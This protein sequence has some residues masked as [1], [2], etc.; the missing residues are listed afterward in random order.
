MAI[1]IVVPR[2]GWSMDEGTFV[3]WLI[4]DGALVS[5]GDM[6]YEL[7]GEKT[8]EEIESFDEGI[9]YIPADAPRPGDT[10]AVGTRLAYLLAE[11][12]TPPVV[13]QEEYGSSNV[14]RPSQENEEVPRQDVR[15]GNSPHG[16]RGGEQPSSARVSASPRALR[17]ARELGVDCSNIQGSGRNG[18]VRQRDVIAVAGRSSAPNRC[19]DEGASLAAR[20]PSSK[21]RRTIAHRMLAGAQQTAPVTLTTRV[22]ASGLVSVRQGFKAEG[23]PYVPSYNDF[24]VKLV[25]VS[26]TECPEMNASWGNNAVEFN[27]EIN[28][29]IAVDT[30]HGLVAPVLRSVPALSLDEIASQSRLLAEKARSG[31]LSEHNLRGGTFTVTNLGMF[32]VDYFTPIINVPQT[33]VLGVGRIADEP[34]I[35]ENKVI[36]GKTL[37]LSLTFDHRVIDGAPAARWLQRLSK[38][39]TAI[40]RSD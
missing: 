9:L 5:K 19:K 24:L 38:K 36:A 18:R 40:A 23:V 13:K 21:I 8:S 20:K 26:L 33:A 12:E 35:R 6:L 16:S 14:R 3:E 34:V 29:A 32:D 39:I 15:A 25:A 4:P 27:D 11:G 31:S 37:S 17:T 1:E 10:V 30:D 22:D 28:I 7:E 2:L